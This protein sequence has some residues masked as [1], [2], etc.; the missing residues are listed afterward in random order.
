MTN[1]VLL[2]SRTS[3]GLDQSALSGISFTEN[4]HVTDNDKPL[5]PLFEP[6]MV[7]GRFQDHED[8]VADQN[9]GHARLQIQESV[10]HD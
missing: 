5:E 6:F 3:L 1:E 4:S 9:H 8:D 2:S 7:E 10:I